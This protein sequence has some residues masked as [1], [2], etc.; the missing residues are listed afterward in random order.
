MR[1]ASCG[2]PRARNKVP[3]RRPKR[4]RNGSSGLCGSSRLKR[5]PRYEGVVVNVPEKGLR[6]MGKMFEDGWC[7]DCH[8]TR[9]CTGRKRCVLRPGCMGGTRLAWTACDRPS[10][11][12]ADEEPENVTEARTQSV[13]YGW[14][15]MAGEMELS[16]RCW[17]LDVLLGYSSGS[18]SAACAR[19]FSARGGGRS[20]A[21]SSTWMSTGALPQA[22][23]VKR[24]YTVEVAR[25]PRVHPGRP[26]C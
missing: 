13:S 24:L 4:C 17:S 12:R 19:K 3:E 25:G 26:V 8:D 14:N 20:I 9:W 5:G 21:S 16:A 10:R 18:R 1:N 7:C 2:D 22:T 15:G 23:R 11:G 6:A